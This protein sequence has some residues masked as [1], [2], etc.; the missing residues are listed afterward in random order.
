MI[1]KNLSTA[2]VYSLRHPFYVIRTLS[3]EKVDALNDLETGSESCS[4]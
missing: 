1:Q 3:I 2:L 4:S